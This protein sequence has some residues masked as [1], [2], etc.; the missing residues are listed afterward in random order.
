[1]MILLNVRRKAFLLLAC[2]M[3]VLGGAAKAQE[4]NWPT[5]SEEDLRKI[6]TGATLTGE[7]KAEPP[8]NFSEFL[9]SDGKSR[10]KMIE[11]CKPEQVVSNGMSYAGEWTLEKDN[12]CVTYEGEADK[13][14]WRLQVKGD[15]FRMTDQKFGR[16]GEGQI[17]AGNPD[18]L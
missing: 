10:G 13:I 12:L 7:V 11:C 16:V 2:G 18:N 9:A 6:I 8:F 15:R 1:M 14:C 17:R 4:D 3:L 5:S